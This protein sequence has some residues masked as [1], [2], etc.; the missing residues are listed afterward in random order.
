MEETWDQPPAQSWTHSRNWNRGTFDHSR[1]Y[2]EIVQKIWEQPQLKL[3]SHALFLPTSSFFKFLVSYKKSSMKQQE[4]HW[5]WTSRNSFIDRFIH[6]LQSWLEQEVAWLKW[7]VWSPSLSRNI[8][9]NWGY[10]VWRL[11]G[12]FITFYN[13]LT[14]GCSR[15]CLSVKCTFFFPSNEWYDKREWPQVAQGPFRFDI[16]K[17]FSTKKPV[18]HWKR[19]P[20]EVMKSPS[21]EV[22]KKRHMV[23]CKKI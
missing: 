16:R 22:L 18:K 17:K 23:L 5:S 8:R 1:T 19:V 4:K 21:L 9:G 20:T 10:E 2:S 7:K 3:F 11:R 15:T 14:G 6:K 12:E 13:Y